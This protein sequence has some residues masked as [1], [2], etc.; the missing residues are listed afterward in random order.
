MDNIKITIE[1]NANEAAKTFENLA[2]SFNDADTQAQDLRKEIK[3]LKNEIYRLEPGTKEYTQTLVK[4]GEKMNTLGDINRDLRSSTGGLDTVFQTTTKT[5]SS[6]AAGMQACMGVVALFG[7]DTEDL[8]KQFVKLQAAMSIV[9]GLS[10]FS[11][12]TKA[13]G[14]AASS[15]RAF[16]AR[17]TLSTAATEADTAAKTKNTVATEAN[18]AA[19]LENAGAAGTAG[20]A[21]SGLGTAG[22]GLRAIVAKLVPGLIGLTAVLAAIILPIRSIIKD[23]ERLNELEESYN[24]IMSRNIQLNVETT[25]TYKAMKQELDAYIEKLREEGATEEEIRQVKDDFWKLKQKEVETDAQHIKNIKDEITWYNSSIVLIKNKKTSIKGLNKEEKELEQTMGLINKSIRENK[26]L[27]NPFEIYENHLKETMRNMKLLIAEG[28]ADAE[29]EYEQLVIVSKKYI[30]EI[31]E[32]ARKEHRGLT[33]NEKDNVKKAQDNIDEYNYQIKLIHAAARKQMRE[34]TQKTMTEYQKNFDS[35]S[36]AISTALSEVS[37]DLEKE[38][39]R[40][41]GTD[42]E[43]KSVISNLF[44][45]FR[46]LMIKGVDPKLIEQ[47]K[48]DIEDAFTNNEIKEAQ[49]DAL[50]KMVD[51]LEKQYNDILQTIMT[52]LSPD[53]KFDMGGQMLNTDKLMEIMSQANDVIDLEITYVSDFRK[54]MADL[55]TAFDNGEIDPGQYAEAIHRN[56]SEYYKTISQ[57]MS[58]IPKY[59]NQLMQGDAFSGMS[60]EQKDAWKK[61]LTKYLEQAFYIP[62]SELT[63]LTENASKEI[64]KQLDTVFKD[65]ENQMAAAQQ[66]AEQR[67]YASSNNI[68]NKG[69]EGFQGFM[70]K[71]IGGE[72][73]GTGEGQSYQLAKQQTEDMWNAYKETADKEIAEIDRLMASAGEDMTLREELNNRKLDL[74]AKYNLAM[75]QYYNDLENLEHEHLAGIVSNINSVVNATGSLGSA[76]SDYYS[77]MA[78]DERLSEKEQ[79]EYTLKSLKMKKAM[80]YVSIAQGIVSAIAGAMELGFP[81]GP[82][83]AAL[84]SASVAVAGAVQIKQINKQIRELNGSAGSDTP[85]AA[86]MVDRII[87]ANAQNTDQTAQLNAE[88]TGGAVGEQKVYVTQ[89]DISD[90]QDLNRT[91]VT[92]NGF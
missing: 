67:F 17:I 7:G 20:T 18:T 39:N 54:R 12:L 9:Q 31:Y 21:M 44:L 35:L 92:Q 55:K 76:L 64:F 6:M 33:T 58:E 72:F 28:L 14:D 85:D 1:T 81:M 36:K 66:A 45:K 48:Q 2:N 37:R 65:L 50:K 69:G 27:G 83:V 75:E 8:Q 62:D 47:Y 90:A 88:Y 51:D 11:G 22:Q 34:E 24:N 87:T 63:S 89:S 46:E 82:I 61:V 60:L 59:V 52:K 5:I 91:A 70:N 74:Q 41:A 10:G 13:A 56:I 53:L 77:E 40:I 43:G 80:A 30:G 16:I 32:R 57:A 78:N 38:F 25:D 79:R 86:G 84:E 73:W 26:A 15:I 23:K 19:L 29:D 71:L 3:S 68:M 49:R 4:L 42:V